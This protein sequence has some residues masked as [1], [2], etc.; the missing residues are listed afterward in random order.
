MRRL[1]NKKGSVTKL[2][3]NRE[4]P[5]IARG[6]VI[7]EW[8]P[9]KMTT[10]S[11]RPTIGSF[12]TKKEAY[13]A[14]DAYSIDQ[15]TKKREMN[16]T[17]LYAKW[18][19]NAFK[20]ISRSTIDNYKA[21]YRHCAPF[22]NMSI[23]EIKTTTIEN[24]LDNLDVG[25]PTKKNIKI[26]LKQMMDKAM[27]DDLINKNYAEL[28]KLEKIET[29]IARYVYSISE[30]N[31]L[32][33]NADYWYTKFTLIDLYTGMRLKELSECLKSD[34]HIKEG[35]IYV[36]N[37]KNKYAIR[38]V[39]IHTRILPILESLMLSPSEYLF[40]DENGRKLSKSRI[41]GIPKKIADITGVEHFPYDTKHTFITKCHEVNMDKLCLITIVGHTPKGTTSRSYTHISLETLQ[42]ELEKFEY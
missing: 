40:T 37:G 36:P 19:E 31:T 26:V 21:A 25:A 23:T 12:K 6:T 27:A 34:V 10:K 2:S 18:S 14:L 39:P 42:H 30:I 32:W 20:K 41:D 29:E 8:D 24:L 11:I 22:Y 4:R 13:D 9:E 33:N 1:P 16:F 28:V 17:D 35:Y 3:G 5:Y 38:N 15:I 7:Y